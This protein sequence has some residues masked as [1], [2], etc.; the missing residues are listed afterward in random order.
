MLSVRSMFVCNSYYILPYITFVTAG[1]V[2]D[3]TASSSVI[4][5]GCY[6]VVVVSHIQHITGC[7][8]ETEIL[9]MA[10]SHPRVSCREIW[11]TRDNLG[12]GK[13]RRKNGPTAWQR[14]V[15]CLVSRGTGAPPH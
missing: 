3:R 1:G 12:R 7:Q 5:M 4:Y 13:K 2:R 11:R 10:R 9:T 6:A 14:M 8:P 15:G